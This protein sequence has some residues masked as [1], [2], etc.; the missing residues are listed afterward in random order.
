VHSRLASSVFSLSEVL[1]GEFVPFRA[2]IDMRVVYGTPGEG[3]AAAFLR[4]QPGA[5]IPAHEHPGY[6]LIHVLSGSQTDERGTHRA[7]TFV[8]NPPGSRHA[9]ESADGCLVL[10][11][12]EHPI[13]FVAGS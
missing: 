5:K 6:E 11:V 2:G 7:G 8:V 10:V 4:Y 3:A 13:Q 1:A 12:W 9:V